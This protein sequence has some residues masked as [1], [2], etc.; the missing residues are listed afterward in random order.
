[1]EYQNLVELYKQAYSKK[2]LSSAYKYWEMIYEVLDKKLNNIDI[3]NKEERFKCYEEYNDYMKQ[4]ADKEVYDI[5]D[6][7]KAKSYR[8]MF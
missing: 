2:D 8:E 7:G 3:N 6:Y 5:T 1:M 4:F